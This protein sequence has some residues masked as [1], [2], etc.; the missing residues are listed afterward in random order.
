MSKKVELDFQK[1]FEDRILDDGLYVVPEGIEVIEYERVAYELTQKQEDQARA[2][3]TKHPDAV[4]ASAYATSTTFLLSKRPE[5][6]TGHRLGGGFNYGSTNL[7][8]DLPARHSLL[9]LAQND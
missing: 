5:P 4:I 7:V 2:F 8:G 1:E 3:L 6:Y 9:I